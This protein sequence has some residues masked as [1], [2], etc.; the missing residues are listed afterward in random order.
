MIEI[1]YFV[2]SVTSS[3]LILFYLYDIIG[4]LYSSSYPK[5]S[6][7]DKLEWNVRINST[8]NSTI[9]TIVT[10][11]VMFFDEIPNIYVTEPFLGTTGDPMYLF[12]AIF[13]YFLYDTLLIL[14]IELS[15]PFVNI[16]WFLCFVYT[17]WIVRD[18]STEWHRVVEA[19]PNFFLR[20]IWIGPFMILQ[21]LNFYW[22]YLIGFGLFKLLS[23][24]L[25]GT[26]NHIKSLEQGQDVEE[27]SGSIVN[28]IEIENLG[29]ST[30][31][32]SSSKS[33]LID[34]HKEL[35]SIPTM[36]KLAATKQLKT[37]KVQ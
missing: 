25:T 28:N 27:D 16:R 6:K 5:L 2:L 12:Q 31:S 13:A 14:I 24:K 9:A 18:L 37:K 10:Y 26:T 33:T 35:K 22:S 1:N 15:T 23:K 34:S 8:I 36:S 30:K 7:A 20:W 19:I 17:A 3:Y 4:P 29:Q 32:S 11:K 21:P